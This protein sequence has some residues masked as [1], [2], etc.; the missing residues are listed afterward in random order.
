MC[1][2]GVLFRSDRFCR[3]KYVFS[4]NATTKKTLKE[5]NLEGITVEEIPHPSP[6]NPLA[7]KDKGAVWKKISKR[8]IMGK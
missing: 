3:S 4:Q 8:V 5:N 7:N 6:A 1:N 2:F